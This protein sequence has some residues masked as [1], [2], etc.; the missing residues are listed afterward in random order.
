[1]GLGHSSVFLEDRRPQRPERIALTVLLDAVLLCSIA[2]AREGVLRLA[3]R[4]SLSPVVLEASGGD[5][6]WLQGLS[7]VVGFGLLD[8]KDC[9]V[10]WIS[11]A[12]GFKVAG[13]KMVA[14]TAHLGVCVDAD[15]SF[16]RLVRPRPPHAGA[17]PSRRGVSPCLGERFGRRIGGEGE[18]V[19]LVPFFAFL[20]AMVVLVA[21]S[22][23]Q[24]LKVVVRK[25]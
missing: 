11:W 10:E 22:V 7:P 16:H 21:T 18:R 14:D 13:G 2:P 20:S 19:P 15:L 5:C 23:V 17:W 12:A 4:R 1:M 3:G 24:V 6:L 9:R 8:T 25:K